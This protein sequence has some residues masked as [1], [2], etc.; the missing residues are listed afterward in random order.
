MRN[1]YV[2]AVSGGVDSI[3]LLD[4]LVQGQA[5][6]QYFQNNQI[7]QE[8][9]SNI[10]DPL[11]QIVVAH[12][13]HGIRADSSTDEQFARGVAGDYGIRF[14]SEH[15][16]LGAGASEAEAR[17]ARYNFLRLCCKRYNAQL[18]TAHHQDDLLETM[19]INLVR[20][21]GWRGL[22]SLSS[23]T[24]TLRPLLDIPKV[25]LVAYA[26][27]YDLKW[28]EDSTNT[29]QSYLRNYVRLTLLPQ[30]YKKDPESKDR[31]LQIN[32]NLSE[33][34]SKIAIELQNL[35]I[36]YKIS[37]I[38]YAIPRYDLTMWPPTVAREVVRSI[39]AQL[40]PGWH[41]SSLQIKRVVHFIK[42]AQPGKQLEVSKHL[43]I[44]LN[45][46]VAQFKKH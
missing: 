9:V 13:D 3:V 37:N 44:E 42:S 35:N 26:K 15:A 34:K 29:D 22:A 28:K 30:M 16:E 7:L 40:D 43:N 23:D 36:K 1:T 41:P 39:L 31:L 2:V 45:K 27:K 10:T 8:L 12:F 25:Q 38:K 24:Q 5:R 17:Q 4:V 19:I 11:S 21:T 32:Q 33:V 6:A 20:G 14:E 46:G 18:V